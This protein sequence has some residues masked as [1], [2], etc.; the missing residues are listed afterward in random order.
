M[1]GFESGSFPPGMKSQIAM[2]VWP[3]HMVIIN[4][5]SSAGSKDYTTQLIGVPGYPGSAFL[6]FEEIVSPLRYGKEQDE[7]SI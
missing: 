7:R 4:A 5:G 3:S 1:R 6:V 2:T